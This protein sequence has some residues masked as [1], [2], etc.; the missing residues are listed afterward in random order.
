MASN[1]IKVAVSID[2]VIHRALCDFAQRIFDEHGVQILGAAFDWQ[3][4]SS[5][6]ERK[7]VVSSVQ[8]DTRVTP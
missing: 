6:S 4:A 8:M 3:D 5:V 7:F 2:S 1:E